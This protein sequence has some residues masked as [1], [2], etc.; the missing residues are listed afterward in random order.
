[1]DHGLSGAGTKGPCAC[2]GLAG[3][4]EG[5]GALLGVVVALQALGDVIGQ[6]DVERILDVERA[7]EAEGLLDAPQAQTARG[8]ENLLRWKGLRL[9]LAEGSV[10]RWKLETVPD[11]ERWSTVAPGGRL[12]AVVPTSIRQVGPRGLAPARSVERRP[13]AG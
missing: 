3:P 8:M 6:V 5:K 10:H 4:V 7:L 9:A 2:G 11:A 13:R 12:D 1:M